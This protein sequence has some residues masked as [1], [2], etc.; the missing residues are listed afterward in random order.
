MRRN[1][2][3]IGK[4][5][6]ASGRAVLLAAAVLASAWTGAARSDPGAP[7]ASAPVQA[8]TLA[9]AR[10]I[11]AEV[12]ARYRRG[13]KLVVTDA[14]STGVIDSFTLFTSSLT[15][16]RVVPADNGIYFAICPTGATCPYP[17]RRS[18]RPAAAFLPRRMGLELAVRTFLSTRANVVAVS[19]PTRRFVLLILERDDVIGHVDAPGLL[20]A[21][22]GDPAVAP[23]ASLRFAVDRLT[24][25]HIF[26]PFALLPV[27]GDRET[28]AAVALWPDAVS[29]RTKTR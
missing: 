20:A 19:P 16:P 15:E 4:G 22:A 14:S 21:L 7:T 27:P 5:H 28:L 29:G 6:V 2:G 17:A 9:R 18:A 12:S 23:S 25:P 26:L 8:D 1:P 11:R 24:R 13:P 3:S 10:E